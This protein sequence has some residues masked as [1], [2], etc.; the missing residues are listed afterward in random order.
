[1]DREQAQRIVRDGVTVGELQAMALSWLG[2]CQGQAKYNPRLTQEEALGIYME[3]FDRYAFDDSRLCSS[4]IVCFVE[5]F[6]EPPQA[7]PLSPEAAALVEATA[8]WVHLEQV[9]PP[10]SY[11]SRLEARKMVEAALAPF[12]ESPDD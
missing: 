8:Y 4:A 7:V 10:A 11:G 1:M 3:G 5:Q 2:R 12:E 9:E 6:G